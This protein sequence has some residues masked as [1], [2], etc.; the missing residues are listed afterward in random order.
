MRWLSGLVRTGG[1]DN[2]ADLDRILLIAERD[3]NAQLELSV[4]LLR[5]AQLRGIREE[6]WVCSSLT[7]RSCASHG[8]CTLNPS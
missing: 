3:T 5:L 7:S 1:S 6:R 4:H 8:R 2:D